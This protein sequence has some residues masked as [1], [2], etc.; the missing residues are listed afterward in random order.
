M[1][2]NYSL[3]QEHL[4]RWREDG[5]LV[6]PE[7]LDPDEIN[8]LKSE[9]ALIFRGGCGIPGVPHA[10]DETSDE[11]ILKHYPCL[12]FPH[13]CS[14]VLKGY[15]KH[16]AVVDML[17]QLLGPDIK[18]MQTMLFIKPPGMAGEP[19]HQDEQFIPSEDRSLTGVWFAID[20]A[21][22]ENGCLWVRS[23]SHTGG[24]QSR[25][26]GETVHGE[27]PLPAPSGSLVV[28]HGHLRH[29]SYHNRSATHRRALV[30]HY[31]S[32]RAR[33][34]WQAPDEDMRDYVMVAGKDPWAHAGY[35]DIHQPSLSKDLGCATSK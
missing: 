27:I 16:P 30:N 9:T 5:Y 8:V 14:E 22:V 31:M 11:E 26:A 33:C 12:H 24:L 20:D 3:D 29:G 7:M 2:V 23:G 1:R 34:F 13:K 18:C 32:A 6:L 17:T 35:K 19:E 15:V 28:Y 10:P 21:T 25:E 4:R